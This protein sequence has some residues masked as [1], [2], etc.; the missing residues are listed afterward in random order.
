[1]SK[2][3]NLDEYLSS[4]EKFDNIESYEG[5][6]GKKS[7]AM[8]IACRK[9]GSIKIVKS[10]IKNG[11]DVNFL[12][13]GVT[14]LHVTA[15]NGQLE[16]MKILIENGANVNAELGYSFSADYFEVATGCVTPL[17]CAIE[18][19]NCASVELLLKHNVDPNKIVKNINPLCIASNVGSVEIFEKM[20]D[21]GAKIIPEKLLFTNGDEEGKILE[22][23]LTTGQI[24]VNIKNKHGATPLHF[25]AQN[26][27]LMRAELLI[28]QGADLNAR[29]DF[30]TSVLDAAILGNNPL[31]V[32]LLLSN[33]VDAH[34][35]SKYGTPIQASLHSGQ[36]EIAQ[37]IMQYEKDTSID[38]ETLVVGDTC[39]I[40]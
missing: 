31:M 15:L 8:W 22:H 16:I 27:Q 7:K 38:E 39:A 5:D 28:K 34:S 35:P 29:S 2:A 17:H 9:K 37:L 40:I 23:V 20:I 32:E 12:E 30:N 26:N 19:G 25:A 13:D 18:S 4:P 14:V 36:L 21:Y 1:M 6:V 3:K 11:F 24:N 33:K 10:L